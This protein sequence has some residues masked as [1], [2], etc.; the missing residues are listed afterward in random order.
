MFP[1]VHIS[2]YTEQVVPSK[3]QFLLNIILHFSRNVKKAK[4]FAMKRNET[5]F[6]SSV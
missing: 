2:S 5:F 4:I 1:M 6:L 3:K